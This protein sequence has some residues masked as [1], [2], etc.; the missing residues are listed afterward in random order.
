MKTNHKEMTIPSGGITLFAIKDVIDKPKGIVIIVHGLCEHCGRYSHVVSKLNEAG[1]SVYRFDNRG[2]GKSEGERTYID[3][4]QQ[5][6]DDMDAVVQTAKNENPG[7]PIFTLGHSMGGFISAAYGIQHPHLF[8]GQIF[9]GAAVMILPDLRG[10]LTMDYKSQGKNRIPNSLAEKISQDP[11]VVKNYQNDPLVLKDFTFMLMGEVFLKGGQWIEENRA[12]Y[13][14]PC[15]ILH[16]GNDQIVTPEASKTFYESIASHDKTLKI[17][18]GLFH[19]I[20]NEPTKDMVIAD[21][22]HWLDLHV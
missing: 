1:Y 20:L 14:Y 7:M 3:S 15:L 2:H 4:F 5:F 12:Q 18:P 22:T 16:G 8:K 10:L 19:E 9:S 11:D 13:N 17:Y 21:I 6:I